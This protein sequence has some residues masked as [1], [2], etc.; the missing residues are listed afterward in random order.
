MANHR[1]HSCERANGI[2]ATTTSAKIF[3]NGRFIFCFLTVHRNENKQWCVYIYKS[4]HNKVRLCA[5]QTNYNSI[6]MHIFENELHWIG[7]RWLIRS[8]RLHQ[9][10]FVQR[11]IGIRM[12]H[13]WIVITRQ[14]Q[15][16]SRAQPARLSSSHHTHTTHNFQTFF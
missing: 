4:I 1:C 6:I 16:R 12:M 15:H 3:N 7:H 10:L 8:L 11:P 2:P 9:A 13:F 14:H 5:I